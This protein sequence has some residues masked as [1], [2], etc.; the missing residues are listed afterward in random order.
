MSEHRR[1][2]HFHSVERRGVTMVLVLVT[3]ATATIL[4]SAYLASRDNSALIGR[5]L[6]AS[7]TA[8]WSAMSG[9]DMAT[10]IMETD[11]DWRTAHIDGRILDA[12]TLG[13]ASITVEIEDLETNAPPTAD[14]T[15]FLI[16]VA[17]TVAGVT[18]RVEAVAHAPLTS[19][20]V[21]IDVGLSEFAMAAV[22]SIELNDQSTVATWPA[23]PSWPGSPTP[24]ITTL[25]AAGTVRLE[26][27]A[28]AVDVDVFLPP[29]GNSSMVSGSGLLAPD[30]QSLTVQ[31]T[32][33][34][35]PSP[36]VVPPGTEPAVGENVGGFTLTWRQNQWFESVRY[37]NLSMTGGGAQYN[38][39]AGQRLVSDESFE[40]ARGSRLTCLGDCEIVVWGSMRLDGA[41]IDLLTDDSR[42]TIYVSGDVT[43]HDST[44]GDVHSG[45]PG[46]DLP[47][48]GSASYI[49]PSR[50]RIYSIPSYTPASEWRFSGGSAIK[51]TVYIPAS[52]LQVVD[53]ASLYGA[54]TADRIIMAGDGAIFY[55]PTLN[56]GGG[57]SSANSM[58]NT[59]ATVGSVIE[60]VPSMGRSMDQADLTWL[61]EN[62]NANVRTDRGDAT[63][64]SAIVDVAPVEVAD[65]QPTPRTQSVE[66]VP[67]VAGVPVRMDLEE[68]EANAR[69]KS[70]F[71]PEQVRKNG[72]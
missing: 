71:A 47:A 66:T 67:I 1:N 3:L 8:R 32:V 69:G 30:E 9:L 39:T 63:A 48:S 58:I 53:N 44:I 61:A 38:L 59:D 43:I 68:A 41:A 31:P 23:A 54:A 36:P 18:E 34:A 49:D 10:A 15:Y 16:D 72:G 51:G 64:S 56:S 45:I 11:T 20:A 60:S 19:D 70:G 7:S 40:M 52:E 33:L 14:S 12:A 4:A 21:T 42:V 26:A 55:P 24:A 28:A 62:G 57:Y 37:N 17:A 25:N 29:G 65:T 50:V 13:E 6:S 46:D 35:P 27:D 5:N 22:N 2:P